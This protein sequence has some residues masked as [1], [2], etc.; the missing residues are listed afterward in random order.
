M[1]FDESKDKCLKEWDYEGLK[2]GVFQYN[3]NEPRFQI[4]PRTYEKKDGSPGFSKVG[5]L[6]KDETEFMAG[7]M[8]AVVKLMK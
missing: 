3:G 4:G 7:I 8:P 1:A 5:R 2:F 6:S